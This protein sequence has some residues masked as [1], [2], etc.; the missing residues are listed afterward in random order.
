MSSRKKE[1]GEKEKKETKETR[2]GRI[3]KGKDKERNLYNPSAI[4]SDGVRRNMD[5]RKG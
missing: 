3:K 2:K 4:S 5:F 1:K